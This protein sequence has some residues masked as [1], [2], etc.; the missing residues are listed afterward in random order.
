MSERRITEGQSSYNPFGAPQSAPSPS[1]GVGYSEASK[2]SPAPFPADQ[3]PLPVAGY[4]HQSSWKIDLVNQNKALEGRILRQIDA[5]VRNRESVEIDQRHVAL[6][7][8]KVEEAFMWLNRAVL[9][10]QRLSN[11]PGD[12]E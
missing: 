5:H 7:R 1:A 10:P 6:A 3:K 4:T 9:R 8:T 11:L 2:T 12:A